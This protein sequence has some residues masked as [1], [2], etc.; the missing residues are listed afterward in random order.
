MSFGRKKIR[1][2]ISGKKRFQPLFRK[3]HELSLMGLNF[4]GGDNVGNSGEKNVIPYLRRYVKSGAKPVIFDVGANAGIYACE[5]ISVFGNDA[6]IYC[7]E[8]LK[9][10]FAILN[11]SLESRP[12]VRTYNFGLGEKEG[13]ATIYA[14]EPAS[15]LASCFN[16]NI[17]H[18][19]VDMKHAE[20]ISIRRLDL[21]CAEKEITHINLLKIDVEGGELGVLK[22][23]GRLIGSEMIDLIQFEF[24]ICNI[25][26]RTFFKDFFF[27]LNPY[28]S[29]HRILKDGFE[30][31]D[32]YSERDEIFLTTNY[33]AVARRG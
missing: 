18:L 11:K 24:G 3:L 13:A 14:N 21:F 32:N 23:A 4:G 30:P 15:P 16:R 19:G 8:P 9:K 31:V 6:H 29:I 17:A 1:R 33:L 7:F 5:V 26:S 28:Y 27:M 10:A 2:F 20:E 22:G 25:D 12:N